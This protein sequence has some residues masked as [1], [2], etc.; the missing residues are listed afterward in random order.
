MLLNSTKQFKY[1]VGE[2]TLLMWIINILVHWHKLCD[3]MF[4]ESH[5]GE[6]TTRGI[7]NYCSEVDWKIRILAM[8]WHN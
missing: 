1:V 4:N 5:T 8:T 3:I 2:Y 6:F 7:T